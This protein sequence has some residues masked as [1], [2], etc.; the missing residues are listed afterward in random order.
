MRFVASIADRMLAMVV[1]RAT[2][3]AC[4]PPDP[5]KQSCGCHSSTHTIWVKNCSYNCAC[6]VFCGTCYNDYI[7]C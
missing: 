5:W 3:G 2:A 6:Q 1:P 7:S 4:C